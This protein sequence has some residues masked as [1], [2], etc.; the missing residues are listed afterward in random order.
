M[1]KIYKQRAQILKI[2]CCFEQKYSIDR[3]ETHTHTGEE[4]L[5]S[6]LTSALLKHRQTLS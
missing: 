3:I 5:K 1:A 6:N 4:P 2:C